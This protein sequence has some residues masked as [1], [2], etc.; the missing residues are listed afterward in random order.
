MDF[1]DSNIIVQ[2]FYENKNTEKCQEI[3][4]NGGLTDT[5]V[6]TEA[7]HIIEKIT[8]KE[9]AEKAIKGILKGLARILRC[10]PL[11]KGGVDQIS[12]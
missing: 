8:N 7:F 1:L 11:S 4:K 10:N 6:L 3:I 12:V 9:R 5:L 2:A